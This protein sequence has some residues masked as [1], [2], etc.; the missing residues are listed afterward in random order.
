MTCISQRLRSRTDYQFSSVWQHAIRPD[1]E[2]QPPINYDTY[3]STFT[4]YNKMDDVQMQCHG[5]KPCN[6]ISIDASGIGGHST[7]NYWQGHTL[8]F[9]P[10]PM[11]MN[12][13]S[14][15]ATLPTVSSSIVDELN[16]E[17][18]N[19]FS[20]VFPELIS[21][22][23]T[24]QGLTQL[25][26]LIPKLEGTIA[27]TI[28]SGYLN[29]KFGWESI[30]SDIGTMSSLLTQ[31][32]DRLAYLRRTYGRAQRLR[33]HRKDIYPVSIL[34]YPYGIYHE[35]EGGDYALHPM[36]IGHLTR[37]ELIEYSCDYSATAKVLNTLT[38]LDGLEGLARASIAALGLDNPLKQVWNLI[39]FSFAVDWFFHISPL[40]DHY[41]RATPATG[42]RVF[43]TC[44]V[45]HTRAKVKVVEHFDIG[46]NGDNRKIDRG[47][48]P[49][50]VFRR[51]LGLPVRLAMLP[52]LHS[53]TPS[54]LTL[55]FALLG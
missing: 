46:T 12:P 51:D 17:A 50:E 42:W 41:T 11:R 33:F 24:V 10:G 49:I 39:P 34:P 26:E 16:L 3:F 30:A 22:G 21:T 20:E 13:T 38:G 52:D 6:H 36:Q 8:L 7:V 53:L 40:L 47:V 54:Q 27:K 35:N 23:E 9:T 5:P 31:I 1:D 48:I 28:K 18:F 55:M 4:H 45:V 29:E 14:V 25:G 19:Y 44:N 2:Y 37:Y 15:L 32:R 43:D